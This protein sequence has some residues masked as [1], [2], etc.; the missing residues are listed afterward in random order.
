M[1]ANGAPT[2]AAAE[3]AATLLNFNAQL[4]WQE[5]Q[6]PPKELWIPSNKV[7]AQPREHKDQVTWWFHGPLAYFWTRNTRGEASGAFPLS[8]SNR[9]NN[10]GS[11]SK[12]QSHAK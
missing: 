1:T 10:V 12:E 9:S 3:K 8:R 11:Q 7:L 2:A 4:R 5:V 6:Q